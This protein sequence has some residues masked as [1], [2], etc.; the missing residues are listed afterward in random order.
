MKLD[1]ESKYE[2]LANKINTLEN[3]RDEIEMQLLNLYSRRDELEREL[4]RNDFLIDKK[5]AKSIE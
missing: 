3:R 1:Q 4:S 5:E 2:V